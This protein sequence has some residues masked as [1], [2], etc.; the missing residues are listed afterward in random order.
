MLGFNKKTQDAS[1]QENTG[2]ENKVFHFIK[3]HKKRCIAVV[4]A[5]AVL[6]AVI[7]PRKSRSASADL[8]YTQEKLGRRDIVNVYDGSGTINAADSYTVKSLV[9][10]TVLTADFELGDSIEKGDIL[11]TIDISDVENNLASAQLSVEQAQRNYDDIADM[12]NVR[13]KISGEVSSFAV[14]AGD[15]VQAGQTVATIRDTSVML[16]AVD[17]PAAEAQSFVAGQAAQVM[18][19]TTFETLNGTIRSVSGA[20]PAGDAS[21]MTCTVTIAVPN[22]GSLTTAQAAVAQVNG[23]SSLNS[24]HFTYQREETVVAAASGTV[25]ELCVKEGSTVR[26]D[27]VILRITGKDLDKQTR[28]AADSLRAAELQ[29]SSAEKTISHYT[30]D[31]PISGTIVD[32]KVKAGDKLSANDTAMQN[33]CTIYD[34]SYLEM[35]LNVDELKIRSLE[36]GQEVDITADAVPGETYKGVISSILVAGTTANGSTSYPV[37]VRIDDM[38]ELLPGMNA[39]AKITTASVKNVLALPNAAL[40]RG[41]YVLVTKDSPSAANADP[42]MTAP[43]GYVYVPVKIGVSDDDYTQIISGVTGNDTVAYD[44][45]SVSTDY[46]YDDG[47]YGDAMDKTEAD[48]ENDTDTADGSTAEEPM[49]ES[50]DAGDTADPADANGVIITG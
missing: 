14:A 25:S 38:G 33:L 31:A 45:S 47:G 6:V 19:D 7:V 12:Q 5:A 13:T 26:Q 18:P 23:V 15:A 34:M 24:A 32:K 17:F 28:N 44:P 3:T 4:A 42:D 22:A 50:A 41:S 21:L 2:G 30:I 35:K 9:T 8:A 36:V 46:Y 43:E 11:Y 1:P 16:L 27:D 20:D 10:G 49:E 39:T 40:V 29:M 48:T 37:T